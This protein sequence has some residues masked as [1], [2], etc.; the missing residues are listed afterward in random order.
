M[1]E[2]RANFDVFLA[3]SR[4]EEGLAETVKYAMRDAGI[5]VFDAR[6]L[7]QGQPSSGLLLDA[8]EESAAV[9]VTG[10]KSIA[11][12]S[13]LTELGAAMAWQKPIYVVYSSG[14]PHEWPMLRGRVELVREEDLSRLIKT[15]QNAIAPLSESN[16]DLLR[17]LYVRLGV[18]TDQLRSQ[19]S[20][21]EILTNAFAALTDMNISGGRLVRELIRLRKNNQL[22]ALSKNKTVK[23][24]RKK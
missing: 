15:L 16:L 19:P 13:V 8:I 22:P 20:S 1:A 17:K 24:K 23:K 7:V 2:K 14:E 12:G 9:V 6:D 21:M 11:N 18:P 4:N 10:A 5:G 3:Y